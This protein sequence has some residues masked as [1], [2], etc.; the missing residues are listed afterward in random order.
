MLELVRPCKKQ[1]SWRN[2]PAPNETDFWSNFSR[3]SPNRAKKV[4]TFLV[5][6]RQRRS[7]ASTSTSIV[8]SGPD[9]RN[10]K[11][12]AKPKTGRV[13]LTTLFTHHVY[14]HSTLAAGVAV[15]LEEVPYRM[16]TVRTHAK[17]AGGIANSPWPRDPR[18]DTWW[19]TQV[20][21]APP[22]VLG[23]RV[24]LMGCGSDQ[25][26]NLIRACA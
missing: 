7:A 15:R 26:D 17:R 6:D 9:T 1:L 18:L 21:S 19:C 10:S 14:L 12:V 2:L 3:N 25:G 16:D 22:N 4:T 20:S 5:R 13:A 24:A 11:A 8:A 23:D